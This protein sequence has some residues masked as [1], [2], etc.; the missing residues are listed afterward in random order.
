MRLKEKKAL[1]TASSSGI[2]QAIARTLA[3]EG[4]DVFLSG[5]EKDLLPQTAEAIARATGRS[6]AF[7][8]ADF[9]SPASIDALAEQALQTFGRID[10]LV[11]NTG[12]PRPGTFLEL[13][14]ADWEQAYR[15]VLDA[16]IRLTRR[17][18]P[19]MIE[20]RFGRLIYMTSSSV[21]RPLPELHLSNV[22]RA[23]VKALAES[24]AVE[25]APHGITTHVVAPAHIDTARSRAIAEARAKARGLSVEAVLE[26]DLRGIPA[27]RFGRPEDVARLV[28]F[29]ASEES[30]FM[31]GGTH[32]VDGGFTLVTPLHL[33]G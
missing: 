23:G 16:A 30:A 11:Y 3:E 33:L 9:T 28:A 31:T 5:I 12:G 6:V 2:G 7:A 13:S 20:R 4:A 15:L 29:L 24:L 22:M 26:H 25:M 18:L 17:V 8:L 27:G 10:I 21:I 1:V 19:G 14:E 32:V